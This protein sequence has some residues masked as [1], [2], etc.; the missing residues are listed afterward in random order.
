MDKGKKKNNGM[1]LIFKV[2]LK[3][4]KKG[5]R[6]TSAVVFLLGE[7]GREMGNSDLMVLRHHLFEPFLGLAVLVQ[8]GLGETTVIDRRIIS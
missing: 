3:R 1:P 6:A 2:F 5:E 4:R 7:G 8:L